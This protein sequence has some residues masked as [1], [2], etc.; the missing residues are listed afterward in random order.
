MIPCCGSYGSRQLRN[1]K[2]IKEEYKIWVLVTET[3]GYVVQFR[4]VQRKEN[5]LPPI[6]MRI[7]RKS[8]SQ[9]E[10]LLLNAQLQR[11]VLIHLWIMLNAQLHR[12]VLIHSWITISHLFV[13]L[14]TLELTT[15]DQQVCSAKVGYTNALSLGTNSCK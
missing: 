4:Q 3:Y 5:K 7:R 10:C 13:C 12:L 8:C 15:F 6:L 9:L 14:P 2:S 11:L 1:S